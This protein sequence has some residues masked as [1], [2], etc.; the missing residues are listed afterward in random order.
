MDQ[1]ENKL[2]RAIWLLHAILE[3]NTTMATNI[4][5]L[6]T[7]VNA[8]AAA[9]LKLSNDV[10]AAKGD[11]RKID[12]AIAA[13][14]AALATYTGEADASILTAPLPANALDITVD[15][16]V[17]WGPGELVTTGPGEA[18]TPGPIETATLDRVVNATTLRLRAPGF[19]SAHEVSETV[20]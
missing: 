18:A 7:K 19:P 10:K 1:V 5:T 12:A 6:V 11:Q 20:G 8:L 13:S 17:G 15:S 3:R 14:D 2:D 4:D 9:L 16:T